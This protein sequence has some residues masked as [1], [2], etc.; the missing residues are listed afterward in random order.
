ENKNYYTYN[1][2]F[3]TGKVSMTDI[4]FNYYIDGENANISLGAQIVSPNGDLKAATAK[5]G[6]QL[7]S[8]TDW[9]LAL[10]TVF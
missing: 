7:K 10:R 5:N 2:S 6:N 4:F 9:T 8:F 1:N 3:V